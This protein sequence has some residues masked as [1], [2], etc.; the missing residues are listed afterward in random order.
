MNKTNIFYA[1]SSRNI[2]V[3]ETYDFICN[4]ENLKT[5]VNFF[6]YDEN[7]KSD[8]I[9]KMLFKQIYDCGLFI[10]DITPDNVIDNK[11]YFNEHTMIEL[12]I[13][14]TLLESDKFLIIYNQNKYD[15]I[16]NKNSIPAFIE[17]RNLYPYEYKNESIIETINNFIE[18][19]DTNEFTN[20][21]WQT[22]EY[23]FSTVFREEIFKLFDNNN[24]IK[25]VTSVNINDNRIV[26]NLYCINK[27]KFIDVNKFL[28][29]LKN[30]NKQ[31]DLSKNEIILN[32][33]RHLQ[34]LVNIN[35][36]KN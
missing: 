31:I 14:L 10:I 7:I 8:S 35:F 34:L 30:E 13:A 11:V 36:Y 28:L 16:N 24:K 27:N 17:G 2:E 26:I 4:D 3:Y 15:F 18:N 29:I 1:H 5:K 12:G 6:D 33:L 21:K 23:N 20:D 22:F 32:E 19:I 9:G 25:F